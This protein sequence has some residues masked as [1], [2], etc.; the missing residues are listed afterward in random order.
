VD[1]LDT[2]GMDHLDP[3]GAA[4]FGQLISGP[5]AATRRSTRTERPS[6]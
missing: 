3:F 4:V 6:E 2:A 1:R 5:T